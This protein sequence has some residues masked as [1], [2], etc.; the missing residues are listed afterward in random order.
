MILPITSFDG[1]V[2]RLLPA[3]IA[4]APAAPAFAP[5]GRFI[6]RDKSLP[7]PL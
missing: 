7:M 3:T 4:N 2:W 1:P 5:Q 6:I